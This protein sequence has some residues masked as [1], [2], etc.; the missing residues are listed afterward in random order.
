MLML[1]IARKFTGRPRNRPDLDDDSVVG[2]LPHLPEQYAKLLITAPQ[3]LRIVNLTARPV[4]P[5]TTLV[6]VAQWDV[7]LDGG[8]D[9]CV[10]EGMELVYDVERTHGI[11][12]IN[13]VEL[14]RSR[15]LLTVYFGT[16]EKLVAPTPG[17]VLSFP[18]PTPRRS[19]MDDPSPPVEGER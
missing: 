5:V 7:E 6:Q 17:F 2:E 8:K 16:D 12:A 13:S 19:S 14:N 1:G 10:F 9:K 11:I 3:Q 4:R 18:E 15:G